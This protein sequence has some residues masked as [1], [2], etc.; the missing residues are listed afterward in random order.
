MFLTPFNNTSNTGS[1]PKKEETAA[2][3]FLGTLLKGLDTVKKE[4]CVEIDK[5]NPTKVYLKASIK[6]ADA[7]INY[8]TNSAIPELASK[9]KGKKFDKNKFAEMTLPTHTIKYKILQYGLFGMR[10]VTDY[11]NW[12]YKQPVPT[13][14]LLIHTLADQYGLHK[15]TDAYIAEKDKVESLVHITDSDSL[16]ESTNGYYTNAAGTKLSAVGYPPTFVTD[17]I[18]KA[19]EIESE[20]RNVVSYGDKCLENLS[21]FKQMVMAA[22]SKDVIKNIEILANLTVYTTASAIVATCMDS[23]DAESIRIGKLIANRCYD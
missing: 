8:F 3:E 13:S 18:S 15:H 12:L 22:N 14:V 20:M 2:L 6:D 1:I 4:T 11:L 10:Y 16:H 19:S 23:F 17:L 21:R 5:D 9:I 7:Y